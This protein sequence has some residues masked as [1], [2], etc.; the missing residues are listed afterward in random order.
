M[1]AAQPDG[2][3]RVFPVACVP[4]LNRMLGLSFLPALLTGCSDYDLNKTE[5]SP[6]ASSDSGE[7]TP[8]EDTAGD[9]DDGNDGTGVTSDTEESNLGT[10]FL[11]VSTANALLDES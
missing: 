11:A 3:V 4:E 10:K 5:T 6:P 9:T 1:F 8:T 2:R 7:P